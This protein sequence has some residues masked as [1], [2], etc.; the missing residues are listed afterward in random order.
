MFSIIDAVDIIFWGF[1]D[2]VYDIKSKET[3]DFSHISILSQ[4]VSSQ[5]GNPSLL[6]SYIIAYMI[7]AYC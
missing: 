5:P 3:T 1:T 6:L 2:S 7:M 4:N